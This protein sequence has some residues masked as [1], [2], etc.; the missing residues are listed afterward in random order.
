MTH[1]NPEQ[2]AEIEKILK[3]IEQMEGIV[4]TSPSKEQV[5]RVRKQLSQY[6]ERLFKFMPHLNRSRI[7]VDEIRK[8]IGLSVKSDSESKKE[9]L[10]RYDILA[11]Y[12]IENASPHCTDPDINLLATVLKVIQREYWPI[13]S[14][15]H[16]KMD[17]SHSAE[18]DGIRKQLDSTNR[19]LI[20]L[21]ETIEEYATAQKQDFREQ[22]LK[23]KNKQTRVFLYETKDILL[24]AL[25]FLNKI[26][27][28]LEIGGN[29]ILN[30]TEQLKFNTRYEE[31]TELEGRSLEDGIKEFT[32][33]ISEALKKLNLPEIKISQWQGRD[34]KS[35]L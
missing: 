11:K 31:A 35:L 6:A 8:E 30:K 27:K 24:K 7:S 22:L 17:F 1:Y 9:Q 2:I 29:V 33:Y 5:M 13:V 26:V 10:P 25:D 15:Q 32:E 23:M 21:T 4:R 12:P 19:G 34:K 3:Y 20:V 18:R 28:D 14:D 16:C